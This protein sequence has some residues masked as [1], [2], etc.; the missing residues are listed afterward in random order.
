MFNRIKINQNIIIIG[1]LFCD[2]NGEL[3]DK[4]Y[5]VLICFSFLINE[6]FFNFIQ[7]NNKYFIIK[8]IE[9]E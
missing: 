5:I 6:L 1:F 7:N 4:K 2:F 9:N 3:I 8:F